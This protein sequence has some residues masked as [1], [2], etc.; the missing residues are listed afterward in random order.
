MKPSQGQAEFDFDR[1]D[2]LALLDALPIAS[3]EIADGR[4]VVR[5]SGATAKSVLR[6]I[7]S[8]ARRTGQSWAGAV[9]IGREINRAERTVRRAI[10]YLESLEFLIVECRPGMSSRCRINWGEISLKASSTVRVSGSRIQVASPANPGQSLVNPGQ[11]DTNPGQSDGNPGQYV[12]RSVSK[13]KRN[14]PPSAP[15][16]SDGP[17]RCDTDG[18]AVS[19]QEVE[20]VLCVLLDDWT[21]ALRAVKQSGVGPQHAMQLIEHYQQLGDQVGAGALYYRL[22]NAHP[23]K[24]PTSGWLRPKGPAPASEYRESPEL[25]IGRTVREGRKR[26]AHPDA[27]R[28]V[29][30]Q[31]LVQAGFH[32]EAGSV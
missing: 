31:R 7:E 10:R 18:S 5:V 32:E 1:G 4:A 15:K 16:A 13:R 19:W 17:R 26:K 29:L 22:K 27:I 8:H 14:L 2:R 11:F 28:D 12:R 30:R 3:G 25:I 23:A 9:C 21:R 6:A 20:E 24:D